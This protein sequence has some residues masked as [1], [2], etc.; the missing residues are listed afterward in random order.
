MMVKDL[1]F[2]NWEPQTTTTHA[3]GEKKYGHYDQQLFAAVWIDYLSDHSGF[4]V[5]F[6]GY[7]LTSAEKLWQEI[8]PHNNF[9]MNQ[10]AEVK[11]EIDE[12]LIRFND[13]EAFL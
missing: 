3:G 8:H 12:L 13:V 2:H 1:V 6:S 7:P 9:P 4:C 10:L 11:Q 5:V